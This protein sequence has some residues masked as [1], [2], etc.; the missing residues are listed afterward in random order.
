[1]DKHSAKW[2][3]RKGVIF[4][5]LLMVSGLSS[6]KKNDK[7]EEIE[8]IINRLLSIFIEMFRSFVLCMFGKKDLLQ[9]EIINIKKTHNDAAL[10]LAIQNGELRTPICKTLFQLGKN[11]LDTFGG[12]QK[13]FP[14]LATHNPQKK[15]TTKN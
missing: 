6:C 5:F 13:F 3:T 7:R 9:F 4:L 15:L 11:N 10:L 12:C 2:R 14:V 8:K 1:M